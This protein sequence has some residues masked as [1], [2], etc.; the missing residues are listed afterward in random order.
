MIGSFRALYPALS[1]APAGKPVFPGSGIPELLETMAP[2]ARNAVNTLRVALERQPYDYLALA[3]M[4][5]ELLANDPSSP[6]LPELCLRACL[7][8]PEIVPVEHRP[9]SLTRFLPA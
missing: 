7:I 4:I 2:G 3:T 8:A 6:D 1:L 9:A 5:R